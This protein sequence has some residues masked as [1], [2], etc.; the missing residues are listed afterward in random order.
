MR[1]HFNPSDKSSKAM[2]YRSHDALAARNA[3]FMELLTHPTNPLTPED[4]DKLVARNPDRYG[5][6][7]GYGTKTKGITPCYASPDGYIAVGCT[8]GALQPRIR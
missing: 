1:E 6:Y 7:A 5:A 2:F 3:A 4:V 8:Q